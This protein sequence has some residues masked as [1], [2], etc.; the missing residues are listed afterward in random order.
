[1]SVKRDSLS[2]GL[3]VG[4]AGVAFGAV[5]VADH[6]SVAQA[7]FLSFVLFS[8]ASQFSLVAVMSSGGSP[9]SAILT[10]TFLGGRNGLYGVRMSQIL[11]LKGAKRALAAQL[12]IDESTGVAIAQGNEADQR[13]AF[14]YTGFG[15]F[16][17]WNLFTLLGALGA[18]AIGDTSAWG[19]DVASPAIF[20][21]VLYPRG[22][23]SSD[24]SPSRLHLGSFGDRICTS[25]STNNFDGGYRR[26]SRMEIIELAVGCR[27]SY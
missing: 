1:V 22:T 18:K 24:R 25:W 14:W 7:C 16:I 9:L 8:G 12:T 4:A 27:N 17:F 21:A 5:A 13:T 2:V 26:D 11:K 3:A 6:F 20:C 15:V 10:G 19:L 23:L